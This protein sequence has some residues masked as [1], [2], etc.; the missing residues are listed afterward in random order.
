MRWVRCERN[1]NVF[2]G[3]VHGT[4]VEEVTGSAFAAHQMTGKRHPL[5]A[6][7][8]LAPVIPPTFY[9]AG[10]NYVEHIKSQAAGEGQAPKIPE[11]PDIGYRAVNALIGTDEPVVI[12]RDAGQRVHYE[13]ELVVVIGK[14]AKHLS[15]AEALSCVFGYTIGNDV[16]ERDWQKIDRT[17]WRAKNTDTWKPMGPW[18]ETDVNL[19]ALKTMV[20]VNGKTTIEF[21][22]NHMLF[23]IQQYISAMSRYVTLYPGDVIWMGTEGASPNLK[24]GDLCEIEIT[25]IGTL[26]NRFVAES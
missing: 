22:T 26:R 3:V 14:K 10:L 6:V 19:D 1:G 20:R 5:A 9:A 2:F 12:P 7:K 25:G 15:E 17:L 8:L 18:I 23:S 13:A 24:A 4:E 21:P 11:K 16:S